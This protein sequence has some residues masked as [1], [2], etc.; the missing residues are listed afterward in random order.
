MRDAGVKQS[1]VQRFVSVGQAAVF[2]DDGDRRFV[3]PR[4]DRV[5]NGFPFRQVGIR[6]RLCIPF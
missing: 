4:A 2:A 3:F 5:N 1:L 6:R